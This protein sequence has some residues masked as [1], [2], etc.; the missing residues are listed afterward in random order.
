MEGYNKSENKQKEPLIL[1]SEDWKDDEYQVLK[2]VFG[3]PE[4]TTRIKVDYNSV[5]WFEKKNRI[6]SKY[7]MIV[8]AEDERYDKGEVQLDFFMESPW[9][10]MLIDIVFGDNAEELYGSGEHEG[11]F[12]QIYETETGKRIGCGTIDSYYPAEEIE[13]WE[14]GRKEL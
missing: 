8:T 5:E 4:D 1:E 12:Y 2:K 10:G 14:N 6:K 11:L 9:E 3:C 7:A 13:E